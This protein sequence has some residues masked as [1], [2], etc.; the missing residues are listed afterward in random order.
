[1]VTCEVDMAGSEDTQ[2][3]GS[4]DE[5]RRKENHNLHA[6]KHYVQQLYMYKCIYDWLNYYSLQNMR[7]VPNTRKVYVHVHVYKAIHGK[8][9]YR[10]T[11]T[12]I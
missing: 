2:V 3:G 12:C 5:K 10:C 6:Q 8:Y 7:T 4:S 11:C 9:V 1:M